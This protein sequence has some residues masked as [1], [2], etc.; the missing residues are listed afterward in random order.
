[1]DS[2]RGKTG[3]WLTPSL[4]SRGSFRE[5]FQYGRTWGPFEEERSRYCWSDNSLWAEHLASF[6]VTT[7][8]S[9][10]YYEPIARMIVIALSDYSKL[11]PSNGEK[12]IFRPEF[13]LQN[14]QHYGREYIA[15]VENDE[16]LLIHE[17]GVS[18]RWFTCCKSIGELASSRDFVNYFVE[19]WSARIGYSLKVYFEVI[20]LFADHDRR[21]T[22]DAQMLWH[23]EW[24]SEL[25]EDK[26]KTILFENIPAS[27][28]IASIR[29]D[30]TL[31]FLPTKD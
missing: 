26:N 21:A 17:S 22:G 30:G 7:P 16:E 24:L 20:E 9:P 28:R 8:P 25:N 2:W 11:C 1:M 15:V 6:D 23:F 18:Y 12:F 27:E 3:S 29:H 19:D 14:A 4:V 31:L 5:P 13:L 10:H